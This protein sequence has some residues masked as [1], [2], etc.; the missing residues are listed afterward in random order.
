VILFDPLYRSCHST[1]AS[2]P[3][4]YVLLDIQPNAHQ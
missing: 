2:T 4:F 1:T 3:K